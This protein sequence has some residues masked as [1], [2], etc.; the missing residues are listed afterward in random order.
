MNVGLE[1]ALNCFRHITIELIE[2]LENEHYDDLDELLN[3]R[4]TLINN[5]NTLKYESGLF[6]ELCLK[7]EMSD[8]EKKLSYIINNKQIELRMKMSNISQGRS[9]VKHYN[10]KQYVDSIFFTRKI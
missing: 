9:A 7:F 8:L 1:E 5:I 2:C 10:K 4:Q 3:S 6:N